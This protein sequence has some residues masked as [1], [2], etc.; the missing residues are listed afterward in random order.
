[1]GSKPTP[2]AISSGFLLPSGISRDGLPLGGAVGMAV[3]HRLRPL[4][5]DDTDR[6]TISQGF[7]GASE[8][9]ALP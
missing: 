2:S 7:A 1:M 6:K 3:Q 8:L 9:E 4:G 5:P